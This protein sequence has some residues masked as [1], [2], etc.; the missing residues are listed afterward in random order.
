MTTALFITASKVL[1][2]RLSDE[3]KLTLLCS[4]LAVD[5]VTAMLILQ[6]TLK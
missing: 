4:F 1:K 2:L 3:D 6:R 5:W